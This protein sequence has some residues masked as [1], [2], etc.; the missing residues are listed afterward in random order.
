MSASRGWPAEMLETL[1]VLWASGASARDIGETLGKTRNAVL[2]M[3]HRRGLARNPHPPKEIDPVDV[4]PAKVER[5][6]PPKT[7]PAPPPV[8]AVPAPPPGGVSFF[9][10]RGHH[11]R[12]PLGG[13]MEKA[14]FYCGA[15]KLPGKSYCKKCSRIAF[16]PLRHGRILPYAKAA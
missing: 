9:Q 2:G 12:W 3:V 7:T 6:S 5:R 16:I 4:K 11:C 10:L 1:T 15:P 8:V 13:T 14:E